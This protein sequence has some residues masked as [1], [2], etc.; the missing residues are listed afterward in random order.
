MLL[1]LFLDD[2]LNPCD[3]DDENDYPHLRGPT[4]SCASRRRKC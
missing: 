2:L 3:I 4:S 1:N